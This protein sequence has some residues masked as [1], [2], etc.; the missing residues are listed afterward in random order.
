MLRSLVGSEMCIRDSTI[1]M[2]IT[3]ALSVT[4]RSIAPSLINIA[5]L[6]NVSMGGGADWVVAGNRMIINVWMGL[7]GSYQ[8]GFLMTMSYQS[9]FVVNGASNI[10]ITRNRFGFVQASMQ[11][12]SGATLFFTQTSLTVSDGS[13]III[14]RNELVVEDGMDVYL[15]T[16]ANTS[17]LPP[18]SPM[19]N[20]TMIRRAQVLLLGDMCRSY[21][22][23]FGDVH[24]A[25][26]RLLATPTTPTNP[27]AINRTLYEINDHQCDSIL[28]QLGQLSYVPPYNLNAATSTSPDFPPV[29]GGPFDGTT[30]YSY[31]P[32]PVYVSDITIHRTSSM[33]VSWNRFDMYSVP[34]SGVEM[35][36]EIMNSSSLTVSNNLLVSLASNSR[37]IFSSYSTKLI[38]SVITIYR[39]FL[40]GGVMP[41]GYFCLHQQN[42]SGGGGDGLLPWG[43]VVASGGGSEDVVIVEPARNQWDTTYPLLEL[44][45]IHI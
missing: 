28:Y 33:E 41:Y 10:I 36:T 31:S 43:A 12:W 11:Y 32:S 38:N 8:Y 44:S 30:I 2:L 29:E 45:L 9:S 6:G 35:S 40:S 25:S 20:A 16:A 42:E 27:A 23:S 14:T 22:S 7:Y 26:G 18:T 34:V 19:Y 24:I 17:T 4:S 5:Q 3:Y 21:I 13:S 1:D 37:L 39:N 15:R